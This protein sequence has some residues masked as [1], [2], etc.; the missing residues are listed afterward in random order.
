MR[1]VF[2]WNLSSRSLELGKRT[3]V[4]AVVNVTPDSFSDGGQ[5]LETDAAVDHALK[6]LD[7]GADLV[8]IG[9]EST[10][11]RSRAGQHPPEVS[12]EEELKRI[13]P[14]IERLKQNRPSA[15]ISVDTYKAKVAV[16]AVKAGAEIVN[17]ISGFDWDP[18]M[19]T[20][21]ARLGC[22][23]VLVHT[24][25]RPAEWASL[26]PV[27][28]P[29]TLVK[30]ELRTAAEAAV[31]AGIRRDRL[32]LDPGFG[33]GKRYEENYPLLRRFDELHELRFPLLAGVSRKSFIGRALARNG[34]E[35]APAERLFGNLGAEMA[36]ALKGAHVIR[37][38]D[39]QAT[40]QA[41]K[42]VDLAAQ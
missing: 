10:R 9:G 1:P 13:L 7:E 29:V 16:A 38:H 6:L 41:L 19:R 37:T 36:L 3:L 21:V 20:T 31:R 42:L 40:S 11:P 18:D 30:R 12:P 15:M 39:V 2:T 5:F 28:D 34:K 24:R 4:M 17:D 27:V 32:V 14:V 33:F 35:P 23:A 22:G 8:D 25:G 26:P